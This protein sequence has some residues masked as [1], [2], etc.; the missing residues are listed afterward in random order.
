ML[1]VMVSCVMVS[2]C[3]D[4]DNVMYTLHDKCRHE[5]C[6]AQTGTDL[7]T[8]STRRPRSK[9]LLHFQTGSNFDFQGLLSCYFGT[10][11]RKNYTK[12]LNMLFRFVYISKQT[13]S[14]VV[15]VTQVLMRDL[16]F[17][18]AVF[19]VFSLEIYTPIRKPQ[20]TVLQTVQT[21]VCRSRTRSKILF[22]PVYA[23]ILE[24]HSGL[25]IYSWHDTHG[26]QCVE[27]FTM[28]DSR[29]IGVVV[30]R[31]D[32]LSTLFFFDA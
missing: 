31:V 29:L 2:P 14:G 16:N 1:C 18:D 7:Q 28:G 27:S 25:M 8:G 22:R 9:N 24:S 30:W 26:E 11:P 4:I 19:L 32:M 6:V 17:D 13:L 21:A 15:W 10:F 12:I 3:V 20:Q 23:S 5:S